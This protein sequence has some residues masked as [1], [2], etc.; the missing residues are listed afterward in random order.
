MGG[1]GQS[2]CTVA[3]LFIACGEPEL[4]VKRAEWRDKA[5][6]TYVVGVCDYGFELPECRITAVERGAVI[7]AESRLSDDEPWKPVEGAA[8]P[9]EELFRA[10]EHAGSCEVSIDYD[11]T[12]SFPSRISFD[13]GEE[14]S[15]KR[16]QC[17]NPN[18][19]DL[20]ACRTQTVRRP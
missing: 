2:L 1:C 18:T 4:D 10:A 6:D 12:Y 3:L 8:E 16:V 19:L 20:E 7:A 17:F 13:C 9:I 11:D 14:G 15:A 5:P